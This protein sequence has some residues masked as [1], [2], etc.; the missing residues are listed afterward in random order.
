MGDIAHFSGNVFYAAGYPLVGSHLIEI[1]IGTATAIDRG[2]IAAGETVPGLDFESGGRLV[3]FADSGNAYVIPNFSS[4]GAGTL[5]SNNGVSMA[6]ATT[7]PIP[8]PA[9]FFVFMGG[10]ALGLLYGRRKLVNMLL[11]FCRIHG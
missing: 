10:A 3:A 8:E 6:G 2:L 1:N 4:S 9:S 11:P 7:Q 5:L